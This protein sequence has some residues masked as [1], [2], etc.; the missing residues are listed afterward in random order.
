MTSSLMMTARNTAPS[1]KGD[2]RME[3]KNQAAANEFM[4]IAM[5]A[6]GNVELRTQDG[7]RIVLKS[8]LSRYVAIDKLLNEHGNELELYCESREDEA[9]FMKLFKEGRL[10][11]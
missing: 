8:M 3:L 9:E 11:P 1:K 5:S 10:E 4:R 2:S 7:N 6:K